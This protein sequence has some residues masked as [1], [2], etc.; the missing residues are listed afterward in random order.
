MID[1]RPFMTVGVAAR[2]AG[3]CPAWELVVGI[4]VSATSKNPF[5]DVHYDYH[6]LNTRRSV[7]SARKNYVFS[8]QFAP[9]YRLKPSRTLRKKK[10]EE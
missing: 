6:V 10:G 8:R 4:L 5:V 3:C 2:S 9:D 7:D 1:A